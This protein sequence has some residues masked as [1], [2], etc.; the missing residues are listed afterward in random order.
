[1]TP[2]TIPGKAVDGALRLVRR[3]A[4]LVLGIVPESRTATSARLMID[5]ADAAVRNQ[6]G[7]VLSDSEM[8]EDANQRRVAADERRRALRLHT[9]SDARLE[10]AQALTEQRR[11]EAKARR[12]KEDEQ[13]KRSRARAKDQREQKKAQAATAASERKDAARKGAAKVEE[14]VEK[15]GKLDRLEQLEKRSAALEVKESAIRAADEA[16][17]LEEAAATTKARRKANSS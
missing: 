14:K 16:R 15:R 11:D 9:E 10:T 6:V 13:A 5:R 4:N 3:P 2:Q 8:R 7:R 1:M 17:R 12:K